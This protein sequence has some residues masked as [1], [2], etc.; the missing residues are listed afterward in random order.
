[1]ICSLGVSVNAEESELISVGKTVVA[2]IDGTGSENNDVTG[3][4]S[5]DIMVNGDKTL[6]TWDKG[7][8][9]F[10]HSTNTADTI[11]LNID[12]EDL[13]VIT[14]I[15]WSS[16]YSRA[17]SYSQD[18]QGMKIYGANSSDYSD[19]VEIGAVGTDVTGQTVECQLDVIDEYRYIRFEKTRRMGGQE[20]YIYGYKNPE[21]N[22][23]LSSLSVEGYEFD[24]E[25]TSANTSYSIISREFP[26]DN[27]VNVTAMAELEG[28]TISGIGEVT[29]DKEGINEICVKVTSPNKKATKAYTISFV[30]ISSTDLLSV[31]KKVEAGIQGTGTQANDVASHAKE[32]VMVDGDKTLSTWDKG[33][34]WFLHSTNASDI[35]YLNVDL[36]D[37]YVITD[38]KWSSRYSSSDS[39]SQDYQG[40]KV[41][42]ANKADYSD[43][44]EIGAVGTDVTGQTV[45]CQLDVIDEYR[46][47]RFEKTKRMGG[48]EL[49]IYGFKNPQSNANLTALTV[50]GY[51]FDKA[52][53]ADKTDYTIISNGFPTDNK[54][55][56]TA[57]PELEAATVN[58]TGDIKVQKYGINNIPLTVTSPNGK[59]TKT[60]NINFI[61]TEIKNVSQG[62]SAVVYKTADSEAVDAGE[63]FDGDSEYK[64]VGSSSFKWKVTS[65]GYMQVDL[66]ENSDYDLYKAVFRRGPNTSN[67]VITVLGS[68]DELFTQP[69]VLGKT[70][71][72]ET[73]YGTNDTRQECMLSASE[74]YRYIRIT[75][76]GDIYP[77]RIDI[78]GLPAIKEITSDGTTS[79][80][81]PSLY[82]EAGD[83]ITTVIYNSDG[84][85]KTGDVVTV[86]NAE[87]VT[88]SFTRADNETAKITILSNDKKVERKVI[89]FESEITMMP[90]NANYNGEKITSLAGVVGNVTVTKKIISNKTE[91]EYVVPVVALRDINDNFYKSAV[92]EKQKIAQSEEDADITVTIEVP[93]NCD[94]KDL[95]LYLWDGISTMV[96]FAKAEPVIIGDSAKLYLLGDSLCAKYDA[97]I[98]QRGWGMYMQDEFDSHIKVVNCAKGG[99]KLS[100]V[101]AEENAAEYFSWATVKSKLVSGDYVFVNLGYNERKN[102]DFTQYKKDLA[103]IY[104]EGKDLGVTVIFVTPSFDTSTNTG[105]EVKNST[106]NVTVAMKEAAEELGATCL[107]LNT[108][109]WNH[110]QEMSPED[111]SLQIVKDTYYLSKAYLASIGITDPATQGWSA[112]IKNNGQ[113]LVHMNEAGA[114]LLSGAI[115]D[116]LAQ[117]GLRIVRYV[118]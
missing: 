29:V 98:A 103:T 28:S 66:G 92:G 79:V 78:F 8:M 96:P 36:E 93:E 45:E 68:H 76:S 13:Y 5:A 110:Y 63:V 42:G 26:K 14:A 106:L 81:V 100:D 97:S 80:T 90:A 58:G 22:A 112:A 43:K 73:N 18:Y 40:M 16:R 9:W 54:V 70:T 31:G 83:M 12:L 74:K 55:I 117:S 56:V 35:I 69:V 44:V 108:Y 47:I 23:N 15:K 24:T 65:A 52:F 115:A 27:I 114:K 94:T 37:S 102:S 3:H 39:Y 86:P 50:D 67:K 111:N 88:V 104:N 99:N 72:K 49:Y 91:A 10:L 60:Y 77:Y 116:L 32:S 33:E 34:M 71:G 2:G 105:V 17:D 101:M 64:S 46:Y 113:D 87:A 59:I 7:E 61:V 107:D 20:L 85:I 25:F 51:T 19:K 57:L 48:Q 11:Y 4:A 41:Y 84:S 53:T 82:Y 30:V 38:I 109:I 62:C 6:S 95:Y 89:L 118:K 21:S 75:A 1:M